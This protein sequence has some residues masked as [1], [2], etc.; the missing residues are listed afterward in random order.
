MSSTHRAPERHFFLAGGAVKTSGGSFQLG[1]GEAGFVQNNKAVAQGAKILSGFAGFPKNKN[2][3]ELRVGI[4]PDRRVTRSTTDKEWSTIPFALNDIKSIRVD[5]PKTKDQ[6]VDEITIGWDGITP[7]SEFNFRTNDAYFQVA[8]EVS[9]EVISYLGG[10]TDTEV[11]I[12]RIDL[13]SCDPLETCVD[14]DGCAAVDCRDITLQAVERLKRKQLAGGI[15]LSEVVDIYPTLDCTNGVTAATTEYTFYS[16]TVCD[17]GDDAALAAVQ[18]KYN[19]TITR[20][21]RVGSTSTYQM[22]VP[23]GSSINAYSQPI[24]SIIKGCE[25]CPAGYTATPGG[26]V[27][28]FTIED[29]GANL[30]STITSLTGYVANTI[31]KGGNDNGVGYYTAI[32]STELSDSTI[33]GFVT[34]TNGTGTVT[35]A[36]EATALCNPGGSSAIFWTQGETC[37]AITND[38]EIILPDDKCGNDRLAELQN[39]YPDLTIAIADSANSTRTVTLTGSSGTANINVD[40]NNYLATYATSLTVTAA[41][42][43]TTHAATLLADENVTVTSAGAVLTFVGPTATINGITITN[44]TTNLAGTLGTA[45]VL[46]FQQA[47]HTKYTTTVISNLVCEECDPIFKDTFITEAP[48]MFDVYEWTL[49]ADATT[50]PNGNCKC[51][52]RIKSRP[53][54]IAPD[55]A[56]RGKLNFVESSAMVRASAGFPEEI[57]EGIGRIPEGAYT[58]KYITHRADRTHLGGHLLSKEAEAFAYHFGDPK[59]H[60]YLGNMLNGKTSLIQDLFAQY[61]AYYIEVQPENYEGGFGNTAKRGINYVIW[62][63]VGKHQAI[64][65]MIN[66]LAGESGHNPV[67]Y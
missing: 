35:L 41:D 30:G 38:Y 13:P 47:C 26:L 17:L 61:V 32:F 54:R 58:H 55:E 4:S 64:Q 6:V 21:G 7:G 65:T 59:R 66:K 51:G 43:V 24:A 8:V 37:E 31:V 23:T 45:S 22:L 48:E 52:I 62:A 49:V 33:S 18:N 39:N 29:D 57:R 12:A 60:D 67:F 44:A 1:R 27:Y 56:L 10:G 19:Y 16:L 42:F 46:P 40:G 53:F 5:G 14:C 3:F 9:G 63:E 2:I 28:A 15:P 36:G 25:D 50:L 20:T 34:A 11:V